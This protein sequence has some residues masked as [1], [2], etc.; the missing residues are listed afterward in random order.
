MGFLTK[1]NENR[2]SAPM[3]ISDQAL[4]DLLI[5]DYME[6]LFDLAHAQELN[7]QVFLT[8]DPED[9]SY[10]KDILTEFKQF[11]DIVMKVRAVCTCILE[12]QTICRAP[13]SF[14]YNS[15]SLQEF[16]LFRHAYDT[17]SDLAAALKEQAGI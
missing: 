16:K 5:Q 14:G 15:D 7:W 11:P 10:R 9:L 13:R 1:A 4:T 2:P 6:E 17:L 3:L 8:T 12:I